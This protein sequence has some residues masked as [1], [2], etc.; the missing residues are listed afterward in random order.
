MSEG[1]DRL[2]V[3]DGV[4]PAVD[5][6][7]LPVVTMITTDGGIDRSRERIGMSLDK[8][9]IHLVD[10]S[11]P[12]GL[13]QQGVGVLTFGDHH[14]TGGSDVE[15]LHD[16][17]TLRR[18]TRGDRESSGRQMLDDAAAPDRKSVV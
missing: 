2:V 14:K 3:S 10:G 12:K 5:D 4:T 6:R 9:E 7:H 1:L 15:A 11:V 8:G 16:A 13:L 18:P 17:L